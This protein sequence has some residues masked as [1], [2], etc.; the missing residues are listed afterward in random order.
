MDEF[1]LTLGWVLGAKFL[2]AWFGG[3]LVGIA[4]LVAGK[5]LEQLL[6]WFGYC[7]RTVK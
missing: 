5:S 2:T 1:G 6:E 7:N 3:P 4:G